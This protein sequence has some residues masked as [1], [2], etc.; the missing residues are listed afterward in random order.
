MRFVIMA[1]CGMA[2]GALAT[3]LLVW[4]A[5]RQLAPLPPGTLIRPMGFAVLVLAGSIVGFSAGVAGGIGTII[6]APRRPL[7]YILGICSVLSG[8]CP[9]Y[10]PRYV[11]FCIIATRGLIL[12]D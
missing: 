12:E 10:V 11:S 2:P 5:Y 1:G 6:L 3:G 7:A 8:L 4:E 9:W